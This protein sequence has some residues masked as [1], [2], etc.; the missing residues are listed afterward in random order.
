MYIYVDGVGLTPGRTLVCTLTLQ[1][2]TIHKNYNLLLKHD[3]HIVGE[4]TIPISHCLLANKGVS[5]AAI[6]KVMSHPVA[7]EQC[8]T[9]IKTQG[10]TKEL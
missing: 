7:L 2:G 5:M 6:S 10:L 9:Y 4:V 8:E 1:A 3:L